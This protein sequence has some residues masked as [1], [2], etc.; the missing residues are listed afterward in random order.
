MKT[1]LTL[2]PGIAFCVAITLVAYVLQIIEQRALGH[3]Y[4]EALVLAI[5][6]GTAI[7]TVMGERQV[8]R[9]GIAFSAKMLLETAVVLLGASLSLRLVAAAG[10]A[11]L[12]GV[13]IIV[14]VALTASYLICRALSLPP[15]LSVLVASGNSICGN[16]AIA[17]VAPIIG[18]SGEEIAS[19]IAFTAILGV[20]VVLGLP[21][22]I[23]V[24]RLSDYQYGVLAGLTV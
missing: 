14:V 18:A 1:S 24:L 12:F 17:A 20:A 8:L 13:V 23:G 6:L 11:L 22:L 7:R 19:S 9:A 5:L 2:L 21:L 10:P 16:S 3:P 4:V 15:R